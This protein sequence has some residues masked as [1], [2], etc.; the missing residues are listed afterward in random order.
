MKQILEENFKELN[1][2]HIKFKKLNSGIAGVK[3]NL[4][5]NVIY[6]D[7]VVRELPED[8][9]GYV[10]LHELIHLRDIKKY[11]IVF[12]IMLSLVSIFWKGWLIRIERNT[13]KECIRLGFGEELLQYF[14]FKKN[15][16]NILRKRKNIEHMY[17]TEKEVKELL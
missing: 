7:D 5:R 14:I 6:L 9:L 17:L 2:I 8:V 1:N 11:G 13:D 12:V 4:F 10:I 15:N 16:P 3:Y